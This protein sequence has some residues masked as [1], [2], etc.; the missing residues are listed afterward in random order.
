MKLVPSEECFT[1]KA[2]QTIVMH[3]IRLESAYFTVLGRRF[4]DESE[5]LKPELTHENSQSRT[6]VCVFFD[7]YLNDQRFVSLIS[8]LKHVL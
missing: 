3:S 5:S 7:P 6:R 2:S 8:T 1:L 4:I